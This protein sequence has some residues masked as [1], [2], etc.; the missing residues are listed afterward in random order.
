MF[1]DTS[2][3]LWPFFDVFGR[4]KRIQL[5]KPQRL[6]TLS[7]ESSD[8]RESSSEPPARP[9]PP[10]FSTDSV[11]SDLQPVE[12]FN[13]AP[14]NVETSG[15]PLLNLS[16]TSDPPPTRESDVL[17]YILE[18]RSSTPDSNP[19]TDRS[20][21]INDNTSFRRFNSQISQPTPERSPISDSYTTSNAASARLSNAENVLLRNLATLYTSPTTAGSAPQ[22]LMPVIPPR[23]DESTSSFLSRHTASASPAISALPSSTSLT[24]REKTPNDSNSNECVICFSSAPN[25]AVYRCGHVCMCLGCARQLMGDQGKCPMCRQIITDVVQLFF[26]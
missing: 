19:A 25:A 18:L 26:S 3:E 14:S 11:V 22:F 24:S 6:N 21:S 9:P 4:T 8:S 16:R 15:R 1:M 23:S 10:R 2:V 5:I 12:R 20:F 7:E 13:S 17:S